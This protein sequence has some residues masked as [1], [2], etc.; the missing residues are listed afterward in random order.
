M[1]HWF[2]TNERGTKMALWNV[3]HNVG[4]GLVG[5]IAILG[6]AIFADWH[7]ILYTHGIL[8]LFVVVFI[9]LKVRDTPQSQGLPAIEEYRNDYPKTFEYES[10]HEKEFSTKE[11]FFGHVLNNK[12]LWS[13][14]LA[15]AF[16]YLVRYGVLDW[17]PTYLG[18]VKQFSFDDSSWAYALYEWAGIPGTL[19]CG[20]MSDKFFRGRR[21]PVSIVYMLLT[22][23]LRGCLLV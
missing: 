7:A 15:N 6:V 4:G 11:I 14:A 3:A 1:V 18:E 8:S 22:G 16:V 21:A 10:T 17:A 12:L 9:L 13:I 2:S 5:P 20:W 23:V 19:L